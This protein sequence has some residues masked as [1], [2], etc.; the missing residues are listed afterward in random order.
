[1]SQPTTVKALVSR[2]GN[3]FLYLSLARRSIRRP[4]PSPS[5]LAPPLALTLGRTHHQDGTRLG[6][7]HSTLRRPHQCRQLCQRW[8]R[9]LHDIVHK[10]VGELAIQGQEDEV[11][12]ILVRDGKT[13]LRQVVNIPQH[14]IN[15]WY[16]RRILALLASEQFPARLNPLLTLVASEPRLEVLNHHASR[17]VLESFLQLR[18]HRG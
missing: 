10:E 13:Q 11:Y 12:R 18:R 5:F 6:V 1:M 17:F 7:K 3:A 4:G 2:T 8:I 16:G 14:F 15:M 9:I